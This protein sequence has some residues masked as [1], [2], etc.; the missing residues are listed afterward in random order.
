MLLCRQLYNTDSRRKRPI[1][2]R[3]YDEGDNTSC[4][5]FAPWKFQYLWILLTELNNMH[6]QTGYYWSVFL[7]T[8]LGNMYKQTGDYW[9]VFLLIKQN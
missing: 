2:A 4:S 7:L 3:R 9:S 6:K 1:S 5:D 8:E